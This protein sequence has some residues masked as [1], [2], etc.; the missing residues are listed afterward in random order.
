M[1]TNENPSH[2]R[3]TWA[4]DAGLE[5]RPGVPRE[6]EPHPVA[7]THWTEPPNQT[8]TAPILIRSDLDRPTP[9]F[10]TA[11]PPKGAIA[12]LRAIAYRIPDRFVRHWV[13]LLVADRMDALKNLPVWL[14]NANSFPAK[15]DTK[16][17]AA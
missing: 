7:G 1:N 6:T 16:Q 9:V 5:N 17:S 12:Q 2:E 13:L 8:V 14:A 15:N 10:S 3:E 4:I 11:L